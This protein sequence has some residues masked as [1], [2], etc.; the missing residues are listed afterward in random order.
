MKF[1]TDFVT[2]SSSSSFIITNTS[3]RPIN[4]QGI[5][6]ELKYE[7]ERICNEFGIKNWTFEDFIKDS[8]NR[9]KEDIAPGESISIECEDSG[10]CFDMTIYYSIDYGNKVDYSTFSIEFDEDHY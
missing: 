10:W 2:N 5:A 4:G 9:I 1:R 7:F 6:F 8:M 3:N